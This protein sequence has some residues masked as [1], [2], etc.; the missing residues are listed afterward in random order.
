MDCLTAMKK[1]YQ[2]FL[3]MRDGVVRDAAYGDCGIW[4]RPK[5]WKGLQAL[6]PDADAPI[7]FKMVPDHRG[8]RSAYLPTL[9]E[10]C[11]EWEVITPNQF[12]EESE[13]FDRRN[14]LSHV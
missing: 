8:G 13:E 9:T 5:S 10:L 3:V 4:V 7:R 1:A 12:Y 6:V 14:G 2:A 11:E